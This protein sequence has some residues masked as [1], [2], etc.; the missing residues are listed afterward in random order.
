[1]TQIVFENR[2]VTTA[3][4]A[5]GVGLK[6]KVKKKN[7]TSHIMQALDLITLSLAAKWLIT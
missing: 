5:A 7:N 2:H 4:M 6:K 1:M 3:K